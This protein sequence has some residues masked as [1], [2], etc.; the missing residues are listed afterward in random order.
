MKKNFCWGQGFT[1]LFLLLEG[2]TPKI[3]D[4]EFDHNKLHAMCGGTTTHTSRSGLQ[5]EGFLERLG[6]LIPVGSWRVDTRN[7]H[8]YQFFLPICQTID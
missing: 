4:V 3:L 1:D 5:G 2:K 7:N 6:S 8:E